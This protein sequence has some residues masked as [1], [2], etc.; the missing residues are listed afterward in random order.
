MGSYPRVRGQGGGTCAASSAWPG[1]TDRARPPREHRG[2]AG[3]PGTH[4]TSEWKGEDTSASRSC[5]GSGAG[6]TPAWGAWPWLCISRFNQHGGCGWEGGPLSASIAAQ[7]TCLVCGPSGNVGRP[8]GKYFSILGRGAGEYGDPVGEFSW[9]ACWKS[10][11]DPE[12]SELLDSASCLGPVAQIG[13]LPSPVSLSGLSHVSPHTAQ[14][15]GSAGSLVPGPRPSG[16][17]A[18]PLQACL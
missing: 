17:L 1:S 11:G 3:P 4:V 14:G 8:E 13:S 15:G 7:T 9:P 5:P 10:A 2:L 18:R 12:D 6:V 16:P